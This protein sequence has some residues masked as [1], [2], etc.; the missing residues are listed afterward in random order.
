MLKGDSEQVDPIHGSTS[1]PFMPCGCERN[2]PLTVRLELVEGLVQR[3]LYL[4]AFKNH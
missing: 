1:L 2:Q 4:T 3:L